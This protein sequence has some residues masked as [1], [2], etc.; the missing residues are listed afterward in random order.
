LAFTGAVSVRS[1]V[2]TKGR[3]SRRRQLGF[4]HVHPR[5]EGSQTE[6]RALQTDS[7]ANGITRSRESE[8]LAFGPAGP[9]TGKRGYTPG[10]WAL[11]PAPFGSTYLRSQCRRFRPK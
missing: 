11:A 10:N 5:H 9:P 4:L 1:N 7:V 2:A 3:L 6:V 8:S